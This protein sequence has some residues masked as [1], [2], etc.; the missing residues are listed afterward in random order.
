MKSVFNVYNEQGNI[1][2]SSNFNFL[3]LARSGHPEFVMATK[4]SYGV[5]SAP[6]TEYVYKFRVKSKNI[7]ITFVYLDIS[8]N[9]ILNGKQNNGGH[10]LRSFLLS[11]ARIDGDYVNL[12][13]LSNH[14]Y[15]L[16]NF[17]SKIRIFAFDFYDTNADKE[18]KVGLNIYKNDG[19][20]AYS[21]NKICL[22]L[23]SVQTIPVIKSESAKNSMSFGHTTYYGYHNINGWVVDENRNYEQR[24]FAFKIVDSNKKFAVYTNYIRTIHRYS[25]HTEF[26]GE[27]QVSEN[28]YGINGGCVSIAPV[29]EY[30]IY[31]TLMNLPQNG[32]TVYDENYKGG[33][34]L[35]HNGGDLMAKPPELFLIDISEYPFPYN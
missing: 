22:D 13:F 17:L 27:Y 32:K 1:T 12:Y 3:K 16:N 28:Y 7:P 34:P 11:D 10:E 20:L 21:T 14:D 33:L 30:E 23:H 19:S 2:L 9:D 8:S 31:H 18:T 5:T 25:Y 24:K 15:R 29:G 26:G 4:G 35:M 6:R